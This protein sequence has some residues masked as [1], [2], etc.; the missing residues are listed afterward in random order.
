MQANSTPAPAVRF[1]AVICLYDDHEYLEITLAGVIDQ[2]DHVLFLMSDVPWNGQPG[3]NSET[4]RQVEAFVGKH[5]KCEFRRGHWTNEWDQRNYGLAVSSELG[6][7]YS[8]VLDSDEIYAS[9]DF[10][11][12]REFILQHQQFAAFHIE[13]NTYWTKD[14]YR[15]EPREGYR[16]LVCVKTNN[17]FFTVIR[18]GT[19][20]VQRNGARTWVSGEG[21]NGTLIPPQVAICYHLSYA[22]DDAYMRRKLETNSHA[23]EFLAD[24]Y[25]RVW[26]AWTPEMTNL[27]PVTPAQYQRAVEEDLSSLPPQL[28]QLITAER[29][30]HSS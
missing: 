24:W 25:E 12:I 1:G 21:Y 16:P 22:R 4:I 13:W 9:Q 14:Y 3:D 10:A 18:G 7:D 20:A 27:H 19:T 5:P 11:R 30:R 15:I 23:K 2:L 8:F 28:Q 26:R 17:F 29:R 6:L